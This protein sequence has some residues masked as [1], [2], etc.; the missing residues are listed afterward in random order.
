MQIKTA[1]GIVT[2]EEAETILISGYNAQGSQVD[3][4]T[5]VVWSS[6]ASDGRSFITPAAA[7][8]CLSAG[9]V[10]ETVGTAKYTHRILAYGPSTAKSWGV[11]TTYIPGVPL[12][13]VAAKNY[14]SYGT[15]GQLYGLVASEVPQGVHYVALQTNSSV[16]TTN[17]K[18]FVRC[19]G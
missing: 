19:I 9:I 2:G 14:V 4:Y 8:L 6:V 16:A 17:T 10:Q 13:L 7:S 11:A 15:V 5:P 18:V 1:T 12:I 3:Q